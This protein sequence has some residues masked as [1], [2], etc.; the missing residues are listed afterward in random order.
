MYSRGKKSERE[1][2]HTTWLSRRTVAKWLHG[3][4]AG[5]PKYRCG[6]QPNKLSAFHEVLVQALMAG[7]YAGGYTRVTDF[8][9]AWRRGEEQSVAANA[10]VPRVFELGEAF[11]FDWSEEGLVVGAST[12]GC[13]GRT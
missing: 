9:R 1:I 13:R 4:L 7:G 2:A 5:G 11:Q 6:E 3:P 8:V 10:F 12:I